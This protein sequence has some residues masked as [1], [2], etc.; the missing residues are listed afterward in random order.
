MNILLV[1]DDGYNAEG[2]K[3]LKEKLDKYGTVYVVAPKTQMSSK[4]TAINVHGFDVEKI[5]EFNYKIDGTPAD[6]VNFAIT[7]IPVKFDITFSGINDGVNLSFYTTWSGTVGAC[8]ESIIYQV[9]AVAIS[10]EK[11]Y[12]KQ[13]L[14]HIDEV[15]EFVFNNKLYSPRY[16]TN[17][18]FPYYDECKGIKVTELDYNDFKYY[19]EKP[20]WIIHN[21][22]DDDNFKN[23]KGDLYALSHGYVSICPVALYHTNK[24]D[25]IDL[26]NKIKAEEVLF[27]K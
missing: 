6:C 10:R 27:N 23:T 13:M 19:F 25:F 5:D 8:I 2:I 11:F 7:N 16:V 22:K 3:L 18:N 14:L 9:P 4:A 12:D 15:L 21:S 26:T 24:E 20:G 17:I 1:N